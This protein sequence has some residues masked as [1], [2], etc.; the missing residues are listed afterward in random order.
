MAT[1]KAKGP[2]SV[3][4]HGEFEARYLAALKAGEAS[5]A[6]EPHARSVSFDPETGRVTLMLTSG[7]SIGFDVTSVRELAD[8]TDAQLAELSLSPSGSTLSLR[9]L[10]VDVAIDGLVLSLLGG[11]GWQ[12]AMR[13][14]INRELARSQSEAR[15]RASQENGKKGGRPRRQSSTLKLSRV[16]DQPQALGD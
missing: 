4:P 16:E 2:G 9:S 1:S 14:H 10:D 13:S 6:A 15:R 8:A 12:A 7:V 11:T 5:Q 3:D